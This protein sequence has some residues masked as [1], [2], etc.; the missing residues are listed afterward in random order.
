MKI[1]DSVDSTF[2]AIG[3]NESWLQEWLLEKPSRLGLGDI[4]IVSHELRH[5]KN[6]GGRL[7][8]FAYRADLD[9]YYEIELMLGEC[10]SDH[11]F[12]T[13][14]YWAR[15]RLK[16]P[17]AR[18]VAVLVA[19]DLSGRYKT[20]I[21][22]LPQF[23][24]FI[25]IE[26]KVLR[27]PYQEGVATIKSSIFAQPDDLIIDA[28]DEPEQNRQSGSTPRDREWWESRSSPE[29]MQTVD[30]ISKYCIE[31][32]G[33]SRVDYS[34][35]SYISLKKGRR[36]WLPMWP[37]TAG[38]YVYIPGGDSG[39]EDAASD[40]YERVKKSLESIGL[41][42]PTWTYTY[43]AGANP[44]SFAIPQEKATHSVI[45]EILAEAYQL[46]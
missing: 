41:D 13:L 46:A 2:R 1:I 32:V 37:R 28:G 12:R 30:R 18:H 38:V 7:D 42:V 39:V 5:Y 25:G 31:N 15:E 44:I 43:N 45:R 16:R 34:A 35:Q 9:T 10:D 27:I 29:F 33:P 40:F 21:E 20:V 14:D 19:E 22:S 36:C 6:R 24:P 26:L 8:V 4:E 17:N 11:G 3:K 23:M